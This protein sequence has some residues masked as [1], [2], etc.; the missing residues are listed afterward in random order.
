LIASFF[1]LLL[2]ENFVCFSCFSC[3]V[4]TCH[5]DNL[6]QIIVVWPRG[7]ETLALGEVRRRETWDEQRERWEEKTMSGGMKDLNR[8][9]KW[10]FRF[11]FDF[12]SISIRFD[13][14]KYGFFL[15]FWVRKSFFWRGESE[16]KSPAI[17]RREGQEKERGGQRG[18]R[19]GKG[20]AER[21]AQRK[22][23]LRGFGRGWNI[24]RIKPQRELLGLGKRIGEQRISSYHEVLKRSSR[25]SVRGGKRRM[26]R[27]RKERSQG[28]EG[29][30]RR[31]W[32]R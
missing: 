17:L 27:V 14:L 9:E 15:V 1:T 12:D 21:R 23:G 22:R 4:C 20:R 5:G 6:R 2:S 26:T 29:V 32:W 25:W 3:F 31:R 30:G 16:E 8:K 7:G 10:R 18:S 19:G 13:S 28:K 24:R 11:N